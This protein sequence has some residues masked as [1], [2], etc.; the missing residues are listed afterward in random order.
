M[1]VVFSL[2]AVDSIEHVLNINFV[3]KDVNPPVLVL[4]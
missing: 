4:V 3:M 2:L 1:E